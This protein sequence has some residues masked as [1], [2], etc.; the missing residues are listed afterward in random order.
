MSFARANRH[1]R[2]WAL[3]AASRCYGANDHGKAIGEADAR[4]TGGALSSQVPKIVQG[5]IVAHTAAAPSQYAAMF[6]HGISGTAPG[7]SNVRYETVLKPFPLVGVISSWN[8][9]TM[10]TMHRSILPLLA[11]VRCW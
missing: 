4:D 10:L 8:A 9:P 5:F 3:K 1:G 2:R 6:R 11:A 7:M